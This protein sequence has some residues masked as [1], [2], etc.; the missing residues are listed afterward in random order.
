MQKGNAARGATFFEKSSSPWGGQEK[1]AVT[2]NCFPA[3][4]QLA[5]PKG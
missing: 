1:K 2:E 5:Q 4:E 3:Q